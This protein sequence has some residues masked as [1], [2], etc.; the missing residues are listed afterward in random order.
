MAMD[1]WHGPPPDQFDVSLN[2]SDASTPITPED[3]RQ[4]NSFLLDL[5]INDNNSLANPSPSTAAPLPAPQMLHIPE[6]TDNHDEWQNW[7]VNPE[8]SQEEIPTSALHG[9]DLPVFAHADVDMSITQGHTPPADYYEPHSNLQHESTQADRQSTPAPQQQ[10]S[11]VDDALPAHLAADPT[12]L[13]YYN[14]Y[15]AHKQGTQLLESTRQPSQFLASHPQQ[16]H[17]EP[18]HPPQDQLQY[19]SSTGSQPAPRQPSYIVHPPQISIAVPLSPAHSGG[20]LDSPHSSSYSPPSGAA[21]T[22]GIR[23]V[24]AMWKRPVSPSKQE[25]VPHWGRV[26][27]S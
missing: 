9:N 16:Q 8:T 24:A 2:S 25:A 19:G 13:H 18:Q 17:S 23:R 6:V 26:V 27:S 21:T 12:F 14:Q 22:V 3:S 7:V 15:L 4:F 20:S 11:P 1:D 5:L 10:Q